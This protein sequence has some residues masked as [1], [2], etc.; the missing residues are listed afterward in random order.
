MIGRV[1][2]LLRVNPPLIANRGLLWSSGETVPANATDGYQT[3]AIFMQTDGAAGTALY[4]NEGSITSCS[5]VPVGQSQAGAVAIAKTGSLT[6]GTFSSSTSGSGKPLSDSVNVAVG[7]YVDDNGASVGSGT[8][9]RAIRGRTLL[10]Y[11]AG[12]REQEVASIIGQVNSVGGTN[13]HNM[14]GVM[15]SYELSGTA[16][17]TVDGQVYTTDSWIQA[18]VIGRVG[19]GSAKTT[20]NTNGVLA[21]VAAMSNTTSFVA[22]NG[23]FPAFYA[24][25]WSGS[26]LTQWSHGIYAQDTALGA[27]FLCSKTITGEEHFV[28]LAATGTVSSGDS[29]VGINSAL[30]VTGSAASWVSSLYCK[31]TQAS[32][33]VNGYLCAAEFELA[34]TAANAS[35]NSVIVLNSTSNHSGSPPAC[36]P[37]I[38]LREYG[39]TAANVFL[40][41]FDDTGQSGAA[42]T[43]LVATSVTGGVTMNTAIRCMLGSTPIWILASTVAPTF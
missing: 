3:G 15:G 32:K 13:R 19:V 18:A 7:I 22:N 12:N 31:T 11:T 34:S 21:G 43:K 26:S 35:D 24:G 14:C 6:L 33:V 40:R 42:N 29:A 1:C 10:T 4:V 28:D 37:Y 5:F 17:L 16:T 36:T 39:T 8:L 30:T 27:Y 20:I 23:I 25:R 38:T 41:I 2:S 9:M